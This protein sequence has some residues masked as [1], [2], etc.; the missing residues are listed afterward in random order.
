MGPR[1]GR[2]RSLLDDE[3]LPP[4]YSRPD[5]PQE[6]DIGAGRLALSDELGHYLDEVALQ[7]VPDAT[8]MLVPK[9]DGIKMDGLQ[10]TAVTLGEADLVGIDLAQVMLSRLAMDVQRE[11]SRDDRALFDTFAR[12]IAHLDL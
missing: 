12:R 4:W 11:R 9:F 1:L 2:C 8:W 3:D 6:D 10:K 5:G 7:T